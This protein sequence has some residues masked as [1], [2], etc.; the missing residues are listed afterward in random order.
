MQNL[1][2]PGLDNCNKYIEKYHKCVAE[3]GSAST[4][5]KDCR[6]ILKYY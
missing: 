4:K 2:D 5:L 6:K 3:A 1:E